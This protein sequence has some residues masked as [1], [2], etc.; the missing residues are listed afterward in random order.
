MSD[1]FVFCEFANG[2]LKKGSLELLSAAQKAGG[3][4][5][6][7]ALGTGAQGVVAQLGANGADEAFVGDDAAFDKY[8]PELFT[9]TVADVLQKNNA[10]VVL[11]SSTSL[12]RDL[13]P[14]VAAKLG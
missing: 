12:G 9:N 13:F 10:G 1:V 2:Q 4:I 3:K 14:R 11:A 6:A 7:I 5:K 8:T